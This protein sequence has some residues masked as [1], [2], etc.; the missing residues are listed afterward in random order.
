M[1]SHYYICKKPNMSRNK[2]VKAPLASVQ[3]VVV[4][5]HGVGEEA[6]EDRTL[7]PKGHERSG[8]DD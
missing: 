4:G 3:A 7:A 2:D 5:A 6:R 1:H 8:E